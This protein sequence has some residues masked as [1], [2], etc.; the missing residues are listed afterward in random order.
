MS[1][2]IPAVVKALQG[3]LQTKHQSALASNESKLLEASVIDTDWE[4]L[5]TDFDMSF[6]PE[7]WLS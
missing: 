7:E 6:E 1:E 2:D 5:D 4:S 3:E